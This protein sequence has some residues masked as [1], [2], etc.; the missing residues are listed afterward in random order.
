MQ[1]VKLVSRRIQWLSA[2]HSSEVDCT[3]QSPNLEAALMTSAHLPVQRDELP[4]KAQRRY[5]ALLRV[6]NRRIRQ[7]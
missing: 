4:V 1:R 7:T 6:P 2:L 5:K 3:E